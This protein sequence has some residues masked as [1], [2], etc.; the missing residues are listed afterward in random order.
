MKKTGTTIGW[1][2][3]F[4]CLALLWGSP[5]A[6]KEYELLI[7]GTQVTDANC[8]ALKDIQGVTVAA[9]GEFKYDPTKKTLTM[10][11]VTVSVEGYKDAILNRGIEGL[12]IVISGSNRLEATNFSALICLASTEIKGNGSLTAIGSAT[13]VYV[14][15][16]Y[17]YYFRYHARSDWKSGH[18]WE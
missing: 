1:F 15:V 2:T 3:A 12:E 5:A 18:W 9:G 17:S 13:G 16:K 6:A 11:D 4:L 8:N 10:K 7:A 14:R